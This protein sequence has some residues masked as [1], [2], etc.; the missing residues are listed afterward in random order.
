[1]EVNF[2][3]QCSHFLMVL[4]IKHI[5]G[6]MQSERICDGIRKTEERSRPI[7]QVGIRHD[8]LPW[9][10]MWR[11]STEQG[12]NGTEMGFQREQ[13]DVHKRSGS[14]VCR[15]FSREVTCVMRED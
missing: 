1:M 6:T 4:Q 15:L 11:N 2:N 7:W 3:I 5:L 10:R 14:E 13:G 8:S 9:W 12:N